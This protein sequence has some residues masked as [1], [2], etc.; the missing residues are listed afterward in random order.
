MGLAWYANFRP[1]KLDG[2]S[3]M[4]SP[5][6]AANTRIKSLQEDENRR[7]RRECR[8]LGIE[9]D[10]SSDDYDTDSSDSDWD[11]DSSDDDGDWDWGGGD[12]GGGGASSDW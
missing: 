1:I 10:S 11:F 3:L 7:W 6:R 2:Y 9:D 12:S 4:A 5:T 8:T